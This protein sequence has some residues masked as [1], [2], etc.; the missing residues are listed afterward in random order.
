M[1]SCA[2]HARERFEGRGQVRFTWLAALLSSAAGAGAL[3]L[4][5]VVCAAP[6]GAEIQVERSPSAAD[7]P[8][9]VELTSAVERIL[10]RSLDSEPSAEATLQVSVR[11]AVTGEE[12]S[13]QVRSL[14]AKPGERSL[15]D[16]GHGCSAL[17]QAVS[18]AIALLLDKELAPREPEP[19]PAA[20]AQPAPKI[21][22]PADQAAALDTERAV[23]R[24]RLE[25]RESLAGGYAVGFV[26]PG[27]ALLS[28]QVGVR[29]LRSWIFDAGFNAVLPGTTHYGVGSVRS[30]LLFASLRACYAWGE[31]VSV[32]PCALLGV[33]RLRGVGIGY[34]QVESQDLLW[35]AVGV[36]L[37]AEG[38]VWGRVFW[39]LSGEGWLPTRRSTFS[40]QNAGTAWESSVLAGSISGRLGF[41]I[42]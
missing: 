13:A 33:G 10:Q 36:G 27:S 11:F 22:T 18:V 16:R 9:A 28:E 21:A 14:G 5:K 40:V 29:A 15:H 4:P 39:S 25:L 2:L 41:R 35:T 12:Y 24:P 6:L 31:R 19:A 1:K 26:G 37:I 23:G 20:P 38:P 34:A 7:C 3:L 42:W 32:G 17:G 30:T 8:S